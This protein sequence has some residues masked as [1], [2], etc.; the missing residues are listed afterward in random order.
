MECKTYIIHGLLAS[1]SVSELFPAKQSGYNLR[2]KD[3]NIP[4]YSTVRYGKHSLRYQGPLISSKLSVDIKELPSLKSFKV[5]IRKIDLVNKLQNKIN[6]C[7]LCS[8]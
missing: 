8:S 3:F 2:N 1:T 6:C 5:N 4:R 7:T